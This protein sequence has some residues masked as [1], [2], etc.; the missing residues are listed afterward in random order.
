MEKDSERV[1]KDSSLQIGKIF[2]VFLEDFCEVIIMFNAL[3]SFYMD[4]QN[5]MK[6]AKTENKRRIKSFSLPKAR[7]DPLGSSGKKKVK[8][9]SLDFAHSSGMNLYKKA[10][11]PSE[12][13]NSSEKYHENIY[14][15]YHSF[16]AKMKQFTQKH[17][18]KKMTQSAESEISK[19]LKYVRFNFPKREVVHG[20]LKQYRSKG[21]AHWISHEDRSEYSGD[22]SSRCF[23]GNGKLWIKGEYSIEGY[24]LKGKLCGFGQKK[25]S[26]NSFYRWFGIV[27]ILASE[28][29]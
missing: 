3:H 8:Q 29:E 1:S 11:S 23:H 5:R 25:Y 16:K 28:R 2:G 19:L 13:N 14:A 10:K 17:K 7:V 18:L 12:S 20:D 24:F 9:N 21:Y 27:W 22:F 26:D 6:K 4:A 15:L